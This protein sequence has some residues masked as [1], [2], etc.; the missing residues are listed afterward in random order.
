MQTLKN[1]IEKGMLFVTET[2]KSE[3][4]NIV[5]SSFTGGVHKTKGRTVASFSF[6]G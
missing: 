6:S 4:N 3:Q 1:M 2:D 5:A